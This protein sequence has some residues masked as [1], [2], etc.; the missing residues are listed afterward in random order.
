MVAHSVRQVV[1]IVMSEDKKTNFEKSLEDTLGIAPSPPI[2][3]DEPPKPMP[4]EKQQLE[5]DYNYARQNLYQVIE[6]GGSALDELVHLAKAS[7]NARAYEVVGQLIKTLSDANKDLL[8]IQNK[9]KRLRGEDST[10]NTKINNALFV[11]STAELQ[12]F[13]NRRDDDGNIIDI[14]PEDNS[15]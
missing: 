11:G 14:K 6:S 9:V 8:E 4:P 2:V 5:N 15:E 12:K 7:E 1:K 13:I 10:N 3:Q